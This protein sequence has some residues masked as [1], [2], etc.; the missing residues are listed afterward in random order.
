MIEIGLVYIIYNK[1]VFFNKFIDNLTLV[2]NI[3]TW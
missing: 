1:N 3:L 2:L